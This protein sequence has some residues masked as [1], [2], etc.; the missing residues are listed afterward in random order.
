[1]PAP[2]SFGDPAGVR[3]D[4]RPE[5]SARHRQAVISTAASPCLRPWVA[6]PGD[7]WQAA[8]PPVSV[9]WPQVYGCAEQ[10]VRHLQGAGRRLGSEPCLHGLRETSQDQPP[11][12]AD[13]KGDCGFKGRTSSDLAALTANLSAEITNGSLA[14]RAIIG[15]YFMIFG[16]LQGADLLGSGC[17]W[18]HQTEIKQSSGTTASPCLRPWVASPAGHCRAARLPISGR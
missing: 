2:V 12:T 10:P 13:P 9:R 3:A 4:G 1:V 11:G 5:N 15:C 16:R 18:H 6:S 17:G 8:G 7:H 14:R